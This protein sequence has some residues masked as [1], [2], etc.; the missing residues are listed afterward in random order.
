MSPVLPRRVIDGLPNQPDPGVGAITGPITP[1]TG[2]T[3]LGK[4]EG[5]VFNP[6]DVGIGIW[7][8]DP[9]SGLWRYIPVD[10]L[11]GAVIVEPIGGGAFP[12]AF[13][14]QIELAHETVNATAIVATGVV[15]SFANSKPYTSWSLQVVATGA[16]TS[17]DV[18]LEGGIA[19]ATFGTIIQHTQAD[20]TGTLK[21]NAAMPCQLV[22]IRVAGL[23]LGGGTSI[24]VGAIGIQ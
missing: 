8:V 2:A 6:G 12:V 21:A 15:G 5:T 7:G 20:L 18:R 23:V 1:G 4:A 16:V 17:W 11:N 19:G 24:A 3:N 22:Q 14:G 10:F 13:S 9:A